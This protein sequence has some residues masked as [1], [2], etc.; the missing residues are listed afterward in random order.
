MP[1]GW[2]SL[3]TCPPPKSGEWRSLIFDPAAAAACRARAMPPAVA[4]L[5]SCSWPLSADSAPPTEPCYPLAVFALLLVPTDFRGDECAALEA[6]SVPKQLARY[7][8][9]LYGIQGDV[10]DRMGE[11]PLLRALRAFSCECEQCKHRLWHSSTWCSPKSA[12]F[13]MLEA[14]DKPHNP[15]EMRI[16]A[17][18]CVL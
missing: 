17:E 13:G 1:H 3:A 4:N 12:L 11:A 6:E 5:R 18:K 15:I 2:A 9:W 10:T 16:S 14:A 8:A 7:L